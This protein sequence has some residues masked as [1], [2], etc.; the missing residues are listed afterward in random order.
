[1]FRTPLY[2]FGIYQNLLRCFNLGVETLVGS[3]FIPAGESLDSDNKYCVIAA[4]Q[5][6]FIYLKL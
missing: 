6:N 4:E 2:I 3:I 1:V 5:S